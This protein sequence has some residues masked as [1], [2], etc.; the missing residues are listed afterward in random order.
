[1]VVNLKSEQGRDL[2]RRLIMIS[3]VLVEN[4][5]KG[6]MEAFGLDYESV[7]DLNPRLVYAC[8]R[9]YGESGPYA[10]YGSN[11]GVNNGMTGWTHA[12][13]QHSGVEGT[14]TLGIGDEAG[15]VSMA[16]GILA[17]LHAREQTGE[18]QKIEVSMQEALLGFLVG[19]FHEFFTG[20][21]IS[22]PPAQV[23]DGY[24]TLRVPEITDA[25][26]QKLAAVLERP[27]LEDDPR[28][29][30]REARRTHRKELDELVT[31]WARGQTRQELWVKLRDLGYFGAPVLS[32][33]EV[34][35]DPHVKAREAFIQGEHPVAGNLTLLA[36]W[37]HMSKTPSSIRQMAPT[38]GQ[39]TEEV[40]QGLLDC[41]AEEVEGLRAAGV[42]R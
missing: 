17:A 12:A 22:G 23:A 30:T 6:T 11:A 4:Y 37:I 34:L 2:V 36:P 19:T 39:H 41:S 29:A 8:S 18:G 15:G 13:W 9:G 31:A 32:L 42:V 10:P 5:Q 27:D 1:V 33:G 25:S 16:I 14:K 28:F 38:L 20:N 35:E 24:F 26:W 3:D 21:K 7:K 40:L